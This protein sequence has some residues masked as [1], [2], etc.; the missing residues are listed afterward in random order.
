MKIIGNTNSQFK[1]ETWSNGIVAITKSAYGDAGKRLHLQG[2][3]QKAGITVGNIEPVKL[4]A[5]EHATIE[6]KD[7]YSL[8]MPYINGATFIDF[9]ERSGINDIKNFADN[10]IEFLKYELGHEDASADHINAVPLMKN[11][12]DSVRGA[13]ANYVTKSGVSMDVCKWY[14]IM[15]KTREM[16]DDIGE[17]WV[18]PGICHGDFTLSNI[19][20]SNSKYY[21]ID[22]LD[23]YIES[24]VMDVIKIRQDTLHK[25]VML[26]TNDD[27]YDKMYANIV[28]D[29]LDKR[30]YDAFCKYDFMRFYNIFAAVN[31][32]RILPYSLR[33][34]ITSER[35]NYLYNEIINLIK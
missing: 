24:P 7:T 21:L 25:W 20:F 3:K 30:I 14:W 19:L 23:S 15:D 16:L 11:K 32:F 2:K 8:V 34:G 5:E 31:M 10:V 26:M 4:V 17:I 35:V 33:E 1:I 28:L 18:H 22:Y 13:L 6:G 9:T 27:K 29:Y 12:L